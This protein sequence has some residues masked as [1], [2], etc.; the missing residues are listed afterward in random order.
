MRARATQDAT[1]LAQLVNRREISVIE[2]VT[3]AREAHD[4]INPAI[5]AV[6]EFYEDA[7]SVLGSDIGPFAGVPFLRKD[8]GTYR[9][10]LVSGVRKSALQR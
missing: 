2:L 10:W 4:R 3:L 9:G 6:V 5:N 8:M 7:E 1:G